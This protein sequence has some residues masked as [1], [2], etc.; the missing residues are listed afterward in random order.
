MA[1]NGPI[2]Q[3]DD[4]KYGALLGNLLNPPANGSTQSG[5]AQTPTPAP[6]P[7]PAAAAL[8]QAS[9]SPVAAVSKPKDPLPAAVSPS[10]GPPL[11]GQ[12]PKSW[13]DYVRAA[14]DKS[15]SAT[16]QAQTAATSLQ[17]SPSATAQ[18]A[19]L[20]QRR[21][22]LAA[23][24]PYRDPTTGKV[25]TSAVDPVT[26]QTINPSQLYKPGLGTRIARALIP[27]R[28]NHAPINAP[29]SNYQAAEAVR[30]GQA[31]SIQQQEDRNIANEKADSE[32]LGKIGTEQR[33]VATGYQDV[34]KTSTAQQNAENKDDITQVRQQLAE[35]GGKPNNYE[36]AVIASNDPSLTPEQRQQ[37]ATS[38]KQIQEAEK[39][40]FEY[41]QRATGGGRG[42]NE[43]PRQPM[44]DAATANVVKLNTYEWDEDANEEKGGFYDPAKPAKIYSPSEFTAMKNQ[45]ATKLDKDLTAKK[46]RPLGVR[47]DVK[48]TTPSAAQPTAQ[49]A[50][51]PTATK[52]Q[53]PVTPSGM[54]VS[55]AQARA[56]PINKGK[57]DAQITSDIQSHGHT[58]TP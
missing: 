44:I 19:P 17:N 14:N 22:S 47:F 38:A 55:L 52:S 7:R 23:P 53:T 2:Y 15:L 8:A 42:P 12:S 33:A 13:A 48:S 25:M 27:G 16:D 45:I 4:E 51:S 6:M 39:K 35:R 26:G 56:L 9:S 29:N 36:Q 58:V 41:A 32:R 50:P 34:A 54:A 10:G 24:I 46:L 37:Y 49:P 11:S 31:A 57:T 5:G 43:D 28:M 40:K 30:Q 20:E 18:N 1:G 21:Q 3:T